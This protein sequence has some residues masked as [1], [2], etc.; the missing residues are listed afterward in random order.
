MQRICHARTQRPSRRVTYCT[1][2]VARQPH[3]EEV[4]GRCSYERGRRAIDSETGIHDCEYTIRDCALIH[5]FDHICPAQC[6]HAPS[7]SNRSQP[8]RGEC[9]RATFE[10]DENTSTNRLETGVGHEQLEPRY[11]NVPHRGYVKH[12]YRL[13][14]GGGVVSADT[15]DRQT[16]WTGPAKQPEAEKRTIHGTLGSCFKASSLS[17]GLGDSRARTTSGTRS[18]RRCH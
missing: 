6:K 1:R 10:G 9:I 17:L 13:L 7:V 14:L 2:T 15:S 5:N 12:A 8:S 11:H 16:T 3:A 4:S 18:V